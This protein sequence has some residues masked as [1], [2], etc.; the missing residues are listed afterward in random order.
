MIIYIQFILF[1]NYLTMKMHSTSNE[2]T[3]NL[4]YFIPFLFMYILYTSL[5]TEETRILFTSNQMLRVL[6]Y[7]KNIV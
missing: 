5:K 6:L 1:L 2:Q 7:L 4:Y 3:N